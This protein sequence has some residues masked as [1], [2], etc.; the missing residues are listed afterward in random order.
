MFV[1]VNLLLDRIPVGAGDCDHTLAAYL[2][3]SQIS[4]SEIVLNTDFVALESVKSI[5]VESFIN[6]AFHA[7]LAGPVVFKETVF[8]FFEG[9]RFKFQIGHNAADPSAA[10]F[11][12]DEHV[13][14]AKL[15]QAGN[16]G[17]VAV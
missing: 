17:H 8:I 4:V 14:E 12:S 6:T 9:S 5:A 1:F 10:S 11:L 3:L 2:C 16:I 15:S 7:Y 13:V